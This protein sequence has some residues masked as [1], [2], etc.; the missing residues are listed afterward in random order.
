M[1]VDS[2]WAVGPISLRSLPRTSDAWEVCDLVDDGDDEDN[3]DEDDDTDNDDNAD[4]DE[5]HNDDDDY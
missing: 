4:D 1:C 2:I 3:N 5:D